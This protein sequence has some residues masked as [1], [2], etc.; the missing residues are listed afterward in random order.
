MFTSFS[1]LGAANIVLVCMVPVDTSIQFVWQSKWQHSQVSLYWT[2]P[3]LFWSVWFQWTQ[4]FSL[5]GRANGN[6]HKFLCTGR[7]QYCSGLFGSSGH[8]HSVCRLWQRKC[9]CSQ[10]FLYCTPTIFFC[11]YGSSGHRRSACMA[12][13]MAIF[14]SFSVLGTANIVLVCMVPVGSNIQFA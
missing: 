9:Q 2:L 14:T 3:I 12:E 7:C 13:K 1:V 4:A 10:V 5:Y 11:V 8:K 6:V